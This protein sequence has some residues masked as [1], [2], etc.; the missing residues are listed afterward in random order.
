MLKTAA[1]D[2]HEG[3]ANGEVVVNPSLKNTGPKSLIFYGG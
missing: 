3:A 1:T 2:H